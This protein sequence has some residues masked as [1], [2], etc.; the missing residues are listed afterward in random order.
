MIE[1]DLGYDILNE[2][3]KD[4]NPPYWTVCNAIKI[5]Y[6]YWYDYGQQNTHDLLLYIIKIFIMIFIGGIYYSKT[7]QLIVYLQ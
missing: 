1:I 5:L 4:I 3:P 7:L 6:Y 2:N